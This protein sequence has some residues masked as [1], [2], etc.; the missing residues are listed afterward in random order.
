MKSTPSPITRRRFIGTTMTT[1]SALLWICVGWFTAYACCSAVAQQSPDWQFDRDVNLDALPTAPSGFEVSLFAKEP[2]VRQPCSMA[3]DARGRLFVGMGPQYRKPTP[4]TPGDSVVIVLDTNGD[5]VADQT[6]V[7]ATGFNAVQ[8]LAWH[9]R[10]LWVAN[11]PDLT[12][13]RDLDG[14][15]EAD[16]YVL[17]Y[18]DLGNLEH[19]L[20][21]LNWA[22]D[23]K[24]YM[25]KG[26]SKG[27]TQPG[28][29]APKPFRDLWGVSAPVGSPD[30]PA[31]IT[32]AKGEYRH[33]YHDPEDDWGLDGG[34]LRCDDGGKNLEIVCRG[35]RNPWDITSDSGFNWLGTDNDQTSGDRVCMPILGAHFGWNHPWSAHWNDQPHAP[36]APVSGPLF[37]GSGTGIVYY[38]SPD[39]PQ[40]FRNV[41]FIND[42][43]RK[44]TFVWRPAWDGPLLR[45]AG[46]TWESFLN[47]GKSLFRPTDM[48]VGPDG[49]LWILG[50]SSGYGAEWKANEM[51]NEGRIF[52]VHWKGA[53]PAKWDDSK[54]TKELS[55]WSVKEL[56]EDFSGPLPIWRTNAQEELVRRGGDVKVLLMS[57]LQEGPL[58]G[59]LTES[60]ET[61]IAW[62]LGRLAPQDSEIADFFTRTLAPDSSASLNLR[63][64]ALRILSHRL[65][66]SGGNGVLPDQVIAMLSTQE[67]RLRFEA[68]QAL[69]QARQHTHVPEILSLL[70]KESDRTIYYAA[71]QAVRE[72]A[73]VA[74]LRAML[75]DSR[76]G[77]RRAALL[78]LLETHNLP[79]EQMHSLSQDSDVETREIARLWLA[80]AAGA[81]DKIELRGR[82]LQSTA[83]A[84]K[85][86]SG[87]FSTGVS[88]VQHI[89]ARS[90]RNYQSIAAGLRPGVRCYTDRAYTLKE[91]PPSLAG[92][93]LIQT[94]NDDDGSRGDDWLSFETLLPARISIAFDSRL[95]KIPNWI[96]D[97][98]VRSEQQ[99]IADHWTFHLYSREVPAGR[100]SIGGNT[101]DGIAGGKGNYMVIVELLTLSNEAKPSTLDGSMAVLEKA[102]PTRG[103]LLFKH[104]DGVGCFKCHSLDATKNGFG[105]NLSSIGLRATAKHLVQSIVEPNEVITEG[106]NMQMILTDEGK[107]YSGV[108]LEESGL[109]VT[110]GQSTGEPVTILKKSIDER[111]TSRVS[112]MPSFASLLTQQQVADVTAFLQSQ[113]APLIGTTQSSQS[114]PRT[115]GFAIEEQK[116]RL[117]I[118]HADQP[119]A[120]YVFADQKIP[121]PYFSNLHVPDGFKVTRNHPPVQGQDAMDHDMLHPGLW[122]AFGDLNGVDFWRNKG[123]IEHVRMVSKPKIEGG[124]LAFAVEEKYLSP[125]GA[126]VC[127]GENEFCFVAG[128]TLQPALP[129]TLLM[130]STEL[131]RA[132][133]PLV[134]G[135][136]HEMGL[137]FRVATP[138]AV[139]GGS[140]SIISDHGG[141]N[142]AGNWGRIG[143][144][145]NY[146]GTMNGR[147][148]GILVCAAR[149]NSRQVWSHARDYG[150][151][152]M[153]PTGPPPEARD[154]P[155]I[156]FTLQAGEALRMKFGVLFYA[157]AEPMDL[158]KAALAVAAELKTL[159]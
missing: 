39:F 17:I 94:A 82:A 120:E 92:A 122:L 77:V 145:W 110:L 107:I 129:G 147:H 25:S 140:G 28:R 105:P 19:G 13:V 101:E 60:Q 62:T 32:F 156:P 71:W 22:P 109:S 53:T 58:T 34:V 74:E 29:I 96:R 149:D 130:W 154:V 30:F 126:E 152:A 100:V 144:W 8:G 137:G 76:G 90:Q 128:D 116:T 64:Q 44:T 83:Q 89:Q 159:K 114:N 103:E 46:G 85:A 3:F 73:K 138:L 70:A 87:T 119:V 84:P 27:M 5:G 16:E 153:N 102:N 104:R 40:S 67:P 155:S 68:V 151:L 38:D 57:E 131:K 127:R 88:L 24:L 37:E 7:F 9:G 66:V 18:T 23:G 139:K 56:V 4:D 43:L 112:A 135:P 99:I 134:F 106:F 75:A 31:R 95:K 11:A 143:T 93:D 121:R 157:S 45:P 55:E 123:R 1:S 80:K 59:R 81:A 12:V 97:G 148:T 79:S 20:H 158:T 36:T 63:V 124:R 113:Q 146:S 98:Y 65:R 72:L 47:G 141:T 50:W 115:T 125:E 111:S 21:G 61:W 6:K 41:F 133:G 33:A 14:D 49:A 150:F 117:I 52:R 108:L 136:Q 26:N 2:L 78:A 142:E 54:R 15:D 51:T 118:T 42:W 10:D 132:D 91:V 69:R 35:L 48:E 86:S